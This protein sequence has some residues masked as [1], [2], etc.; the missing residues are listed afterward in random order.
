VSGLSSIEDIGLASLGVE[1]L[2]MPKSDR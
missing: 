1:L 2:G